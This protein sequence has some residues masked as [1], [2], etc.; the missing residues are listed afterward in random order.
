MRVQHRRLGRQTRRRV[1]GGS[2]NELDQFRAR[3]ARE[4]SCKSVR[5]RQGSA[6]LAQ[7]L[8]EPCYPGF[9]EPS[10]YSP[11]SLKFET[12]LSHLN[13]M[14]LRVSYRYCHRELSEC[15]S[16][17]TRVRHDYDTPL[18]VLIDRPVSGLP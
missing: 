17:V 1:A 12:D 8:R 4:G 15:Q 6:Y 10:K 3:D 18:V 11:W 13:N 5:Q 14:L 9:A 2:M 16:R 7:L